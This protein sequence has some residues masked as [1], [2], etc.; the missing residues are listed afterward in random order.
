MNIAKWDWKIRTIKCWLFLIFSWGGGSQG[1]WFP[2]SIP[3]FSKFPIS[4]YCHYRFP[5]PKRMFNAEKICVVSY[6]ITGQIEVLKYHWLL[7]TELHYY[8]SNIS[9]RMIGTL[10]YS[11]LQNTKFLCPRIFWNIFRNPQKIYTIFRTPLRK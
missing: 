2:I 7:D 9:V 11:V 5:F 1:P 8:L 10:P 6:S 3:I 4:A